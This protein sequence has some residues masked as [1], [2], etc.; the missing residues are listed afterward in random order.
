VISEHNIPGA[1]DAILEVGRQRKAALEQ[2]RAALQSGNDPE[3]LKLAR[4][5]CGLQNETS[6]R[7]NPRLN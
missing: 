7:T 6:D 5:L 4:Q 2:L 1:V 3:A